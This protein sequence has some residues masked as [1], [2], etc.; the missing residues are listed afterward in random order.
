MSG[1]DLDGSWQ[2]RLRRNPAARYFAASLAAL[3]IDYVLAMTIFHVTKADLASASAISFVLVGLLFYLVHEFWTFRAD[4]SKASARR[5]VAN[6]A[7]L[8]LA[9]IVRVGVIALLENIRAPAGLWVSAYFG[10][11]VAASF[12]TNYVLN[13]YLVFRR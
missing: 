11:G 8:C 9:G 1:P 10:A 12:T 7:V 4:H 6:L 2:D 13:R 3:A 5:V